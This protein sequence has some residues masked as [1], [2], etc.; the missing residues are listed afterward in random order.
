MRQFGLLRGADRPVQALAVVAHIVE[1]EGQGLVV[2]DLQ[3]DHARAGAGQATGKGDAYWSRVPIA[4][5][6]VRIKRRHRPV[7]LRV[8][9]VPVWARPSSGT[10]S[11]RRTL[12]NARLREAIS[13][14]V[15][16][17]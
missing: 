12:V 4:P 13:A 8:R 3:R 9:Q 10:D 14:L 1:A 5:Q 2:V 6:V 11:D 7:S 15:G 17:R 16:R